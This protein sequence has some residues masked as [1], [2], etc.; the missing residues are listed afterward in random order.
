L[1]HHRQQRE[2]HYFTINW[3]LRKDK[4]VNFQTPV[5][6][7]EQLNKIQHNSLSSLIMDMI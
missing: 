2:H 5:Q 6:S 4:D 3:Q 1:A 7:E